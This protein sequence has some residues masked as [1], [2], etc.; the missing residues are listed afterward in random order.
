MAKTKNKK[1]NWFTSTAIVLI[2][3]FLVFVAIG[4]YRYGWEKVLDESLFYIIGATFTGI[5]VYIVGMLMK[6][7]KAR[8]W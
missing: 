5:V 2:F 6:Q 8:L 3:V 4:I 1:R 7:K